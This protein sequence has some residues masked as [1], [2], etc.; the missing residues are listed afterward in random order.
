MKRYIKIKT[1]YLSKEQIQKIFKTMQYK[2]KLD[3]TYIKVFYNEN[4][5]EFI[6]D[7]RAE[8]KQMKGFCKGYN[9]LKEIENYERI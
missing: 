1:I 6:D 8:I 5:K 4:S 2:M 3:N 7:F 9:K